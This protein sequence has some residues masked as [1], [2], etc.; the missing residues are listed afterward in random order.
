M[1]QFSDFAAGN[2]LAELLADLNAKF[3]ALTEHTFISLE[4]LPTSTGLSAD[5]RYKVVFTYTDGATA[6]TPFVF[7]GYAALTMT[8][9]MAAFNTARAALPAGFAS[10]ALAQT[11]Y[12]DLRRTHVLEGQQL[13]LLAYNADVT[14]GDRW[15]AGVGGTASGGGGGGSVLRSSLA[16]TFRDDWRGTGVAGDTGSFTSSLLNGG[17]SATSSTY[18]DGNHLGI[19]YIQG[20]TTGNGA[21]SLR[22]T[23]FHTVFGGGETYYETLPFIPIISDGTN[24]F[25][26]RCGFG[27]LA[28]A[29]SADYNNGIYF[30]A[31]AA[32]APNWHLKTAQGGVRTDVD[33]GIPVVAAAWVRLGFTANADGSSIQF[34]VNGVAVGAPITT[35]IPIVPATN[36]CGLMFNMWSTAGTINRVIHIDYVETQTIFTTPR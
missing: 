22:H 12:N 18:V 1:A 35:N 25:G 20:G 31:P 16:S 9:A 26:F 27:D 2:S 10:G 30:E 15:P 24:T 34:Y 8:E 11:V 36:A 23:N 4:I 17:G 7:T 28:A 33:S 13:V 14:A 3:A 21:T 32:D 5:T 6:T 29:S 19:V